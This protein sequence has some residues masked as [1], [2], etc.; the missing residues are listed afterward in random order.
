MTS[1]ST[2]RTTS[3]TPRGTGT[4]KAPWR[5]LKKSVDEETGEESFYQG[6]YWVDPYSEYVWDYNIAIAKELQDKG[7]D[8]VQFD[9]IRFPSDGD[10]GR[11][12]WR[13]RREGMG[14]LEAL[15]SFLAKARESLS[16][17]LST[18]VYGYCGW[19][20][21]SNWVAQNIEM[22]SRYVDVVQPMFYPSH[23]PRDFLGSMEYL[24][25]AKY[26]YQEGTRR[27]AYMVEGRSIIRPYVQAFRIGGELAF[28]QHVYS[29]YLVNQV[30]GSLQGAASGFTLWNAS[31]D[32]YM[33]TV[34]LGPD[35]PGN[36]GR[37]RRGGRRHCR[38][39]RQQCRQER[40]ECR[41]ERPP[42][43]ARSD[44]ECRQERS[45][46]HP[47]GQEVKRTGFA[48]SLPF[49]L[50][51]LALAGCATTTSGP[52]AGTPEKKAAVL[53]QALRLTEI[54]SPASLTEAAGI[55]ASQE[56]AG[57]PNTEEL[58]SLGDALF[59]QLYPELNNPFPAGAPPLSSGGADASNF[60]AR[61]VPAI[62]LIFSAGP[63]DVAQAAD[64]KAGLAAADTLNTAS[65]LPPYLRGLLLERESGAA[66]A[67]ARAEFEESLR[68]APSFYPAAGRLVDSIV[69][70]G[71]AAR[72]LPLLERLVSSLPTA[73]LR[74]SALARAALAAG[75]P[76]RAAD[77]AAQGQLAVPDDP[78]F[79]LLRARAFE[80]LGD[81]YQS[82]WL[83]DTILRLHPD[84]A[85]AAF[86]KARLLYE[87]QKDSGDAIAVLLDA[88]KRFP[89]DASFP[90][91]RGRIL[92]ET[93][94]S[95][96]GVAALTRAI[97]LEPGRI[98]TLTLLLKQ[99]V[100][101]GS[102]TTA[103][104]LL[105]QI[106]EQART[107]EHL[108]LGWQTASN[109]GD[110]ALAITYAQALERVT[111]GAQPLALEARSMAAAG[112]GPEALQV[113]TKALTIADTP[114]LRSELYVIRSTAGSADPLR[115]LRSALLE[116][117]NSVEAL[118]AM[119]DLLAKQ[120]EYRKAMEY[121]KR[122]AGLSP[123]N[124]GITQRAADLERLAESGQ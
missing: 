55:L 34:P 124:A 110:H 21:I 31:N 69:A 84:H 49:V 52:R 70:G 82:L 36:G 105:A 93:S 27:A 71:T 50:V 23:F 19:A 46:K 63:L 17:P 115:D 2:T 114:A 18:D 103:S 8:E 112:R 5:Y 123:G 25:R 45:G 108:R 33:V 107:P 95:E 117:Q 39:E 42:N 40:Q 41:Q 62:A 16:I 111:P 101:T 74:Y 99:A 47:R 79:V 116:D 12:T 86:M 30:Q 118:L 97:S 38:N 3:R 57:M 121:A 96:E 51:A 59:R 119:S 61:I 20:R 14:K 15:E 120:Q 90:E 44:S 11:I 113:V 89:T 4:A 54:A 85:A 91:L 28:N 104:S 92:L 37:H 7:V 78:G 35:H 13:F 109:L 56:I 87:K 1:S 26:I 67:G 64:L 53:A 29:A 94:R 22:F 100:Q 106:P 102:W 83:L 6:E 68:R 73:P 10:L 32:Y 9:Y 77:A 60:F 66:A 76:Q 72:E 122:A 81:W 65:V 75:Q 24:P 58:I 48:R 43:V 80:A 98:S 88:E